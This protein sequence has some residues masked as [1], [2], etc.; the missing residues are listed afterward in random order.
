MGN[1]QPVNLP[2]ESAV[3][4]LLAAVTH[5]STQMVCEVIN[6]GLLPSNGS[7]YVSLPKKNDLFLTK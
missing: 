7:V 3:K 5:G 1:G 2:S 6:R 4:D